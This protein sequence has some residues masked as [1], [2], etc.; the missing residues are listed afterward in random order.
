M[1]KQEQFLSLYR[2]YETLVR[3]K[4]QD[5]KDIEDKSDEQDF[6]TG[7]LHS[8]ARRLC[9]RINRKNYGNKENNSK[10]CRQ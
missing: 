10:R 2:E 3:D 7:E 6:K 1:K 5:C 9:K 8:D 4:G